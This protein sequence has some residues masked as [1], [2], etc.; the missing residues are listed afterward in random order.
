[1][2]PEHRGWGF[3][4]KCYKGNILLHTDAHTHTHRETDTHTH[5]HSHRQAAT[6]ESHPMVTLTQEHHY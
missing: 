6:L 3:K 4:E 5:T 1:M 2:H